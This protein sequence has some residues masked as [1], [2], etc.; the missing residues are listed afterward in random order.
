MLMAPPTCR[1]RRR[2][3]DRAGELLQIERSVDVEEYIALRDLHLHKTRAS[4]MRRAEAA[5]ATNDAAMAMIEREEAAQFDII[6]GLIVSSLQTATSSR[7]TLVTL[8]MPPSELLVP[9]L[10]PS[11]LTPGDA[12]SHSS[13]RASRSLHP[14]ATV[15][16]ASLSIA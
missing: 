1:A 11:N 3:C 12:V 5:G 9:Q 6:R 7:R 15:L 2:Y 14:S 4:L 8:R 13:S 16:L 10:S